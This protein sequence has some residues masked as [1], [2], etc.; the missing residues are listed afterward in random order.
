[1]RLWYQLVSSERGMNHMIGA[2]QRLCN[3]AADPGTVVEVRGTAQ[4]ALGDQYRL[5]LNYDAR[6]ILD[7]AMDVRRGGGYDAFLLGNSLDPALVELRELLDIPVLTFMEVAC[8][9]ACMMGARFGLI[10]T[11]QRLIPRYVEIVF[12]YG[13][14]DRFSGASAIDFSNIRAL[15]DV[16]ADR[17]LGRACVDQILEAARRNLDQGAEVIIPTG[18][19]TALLRMHGINELEGAPL[20]D[21]QS[22]LVKAGELMVKMKRLTGQHV[23]RRLLYE[24]PSP[25]LLEHIAEVRS[26]TKLRSVQSDGPQ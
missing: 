13:L 7:N 1:M 17:D 21:C 6:E 22:L 9:T 10:A 11:N 26:I 20:L 12:G 19:L 15:N 25:E 18:P 3:E 14:R 5:F 16:F 8:H 24:A 2:I 4:G 23:S